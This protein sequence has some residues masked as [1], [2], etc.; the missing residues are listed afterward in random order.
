MLS[1]CQDFC[2]RA[3][4]ACQQGVLQSLGM[5]Q[6]PERLESYA[7]D[8]VGELMRA[9]FREQFTPKP[10]DLNRLAKQLEDRVL[11]GQGQGQALA[12]CLQDV[13]KLKACLSQC[14]LLLTVA[15]L[16]KPPVEM[17]PAR[18]T[19]THERYDRNRHETFSGFKPRGTAYVRLLSP[20]FAGVSVPV[21]CA[22]VPAPGPVSS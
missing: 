18:S 4:G 13:D 14:V 1:V 19:G 8:L 22:I 16:S 2:A 20:A 15:R 6:Y 5:S 21:L 11:A 3:V 12:A 7:Q 17:D 10:E 9:R